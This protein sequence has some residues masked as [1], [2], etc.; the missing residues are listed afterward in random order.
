MI[1]RIYLSADGGG[2]I[3]SGLKR[4]HGLIFVMDEFH[5]SKYLIRLTSHMKD[6]IEDARKELYNA[7][8]YGTKEEFNA[9]VDRLRDCLPEESGAARI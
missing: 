3:K 6:S 1:K 8:R 7:I 2:W 5:L 4:I 9:I